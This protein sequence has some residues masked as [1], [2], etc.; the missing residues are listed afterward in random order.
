MVFQK[1]HI[2]RY[3]CGGKLLKMTFLGWISPFYMF[4]CLLVALAEV[5][6]W[7]EVTVE[8]TIR[9]SGCHRV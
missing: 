8:C 3:Q 2:L 6:M 4:R 1:R 5:I 9:G 7:G